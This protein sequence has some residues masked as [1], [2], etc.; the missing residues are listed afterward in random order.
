MGGPEFFGVV[1]WGGPVV[2]SGP[3]EGPEFFEGQRGGGTKVFSQNYFNCF[4]LSQRGQQN[5]SA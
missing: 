2:F 5:F 4:S 1:K 3:K